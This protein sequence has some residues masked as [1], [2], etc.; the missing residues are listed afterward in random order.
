M[1]DY[2]KSERNNIRKSPPASTPEGRENQ[3]IAMAYDLAEE[4]F[5]KKTASAQEVTH[6]L[7]R[8]ALNAKIELEILEKQKEL[9]TAKT[10]AIYS[11]KRVDELYA[12][13]ISAMRSYAGDPEHND[14]E[15]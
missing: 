9:L 3:L 11:S 15:D 12:Q 10:E 8:G 7:K 2:P 4:R 1:D 14:D 5:R 6:F 13:A